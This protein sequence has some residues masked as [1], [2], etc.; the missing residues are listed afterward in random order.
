ML[1]VVSQCVKMLMV[2]RECVR[3]MLL[4]RVLFLGN[5]SSNICL[6]VCYLLDVCYRV[7]YSW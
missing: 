4:L 7:D 5:C 1:M 3:V 2:A 6:F